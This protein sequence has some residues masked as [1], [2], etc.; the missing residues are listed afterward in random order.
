M[1][2]PSAAS[3]ASEAFKRGD[4]A[5]AAAAYSEALFA[6]EDAEA[7]S[8]ALANRAQCN[9][10]L[11]CFAEGREDAAAAR[12]LTPSNPKAWYRLGSCEARLAN[13]TESEAAFLEAQA[14][15][16]NDR[17]IAQAVGT[18]RRRRLESSGRYSWPEVYERYLAPYAITPESDGAAASASNENSASVKLVLGV[19]PFVGPLRIGHSPGRGRGLF[20]TED[21]SAGQLLLCAHAVAAGENEKLAGLLGQSLRRSAELREAVLGLSHGTESS[22]SCIPSLSLRQLAAPRDLQADKG[23][24]GDAASEEELRTILEFNQFSLPI[25][26]SNTAPIEVTNDLARSGLW[27][28]PAFVNHSCV[29]NVQ[30]IIVCDCLFLRSG[31]DLRA[32]E[33]LFDCYIE[34]LQPLAKRV[35][36]LSNYGI[37][38]C[39]CERCSLERA[40]LDTDE[41][42]G[43]IEMAAKAKEYPT[44]EGP[45]VA[46][47]AEAAALQAEVVVARALERCFQEGRMPRLE[48]LAV[49]ALP[50]SAERMALLREGIEKCADASEQISFEQ[51]DRLHKLLLGSLGNVLRGYAMSLRGL[52]RYVDASVAWTRV[53]DVLEQVLPC[54]ELSA[55]VAAE[56][57]SAKLQ[58]FNLDFRK[59]CRPTFR[60]ALLTGQRSYGGGAAAW[61]VLNKQTFAMSVLDGA[62]ELFA[63]L[64][65]ELGLADDSYDPAALTP[66]LPEAIVRPQVGFE[67]LLKRR[68]REEQRKASSCNPFAPSGTNSRTTAASSASG[69]SASGGGAR[70]GGGS[71]G[72]ASGGDGASA[73]NGAYPAASST[74]PKA[75]PGAVTATSESNAAGAGGAA[76]EAAHFEVLQS[77]PGELLV[78]VS[79]PGLASAAEAA[80]EVADREVRVSSLRPECP[81]SLKISLPLLVDP[82]SSVARWSKR[83]QQLTV[84]LKTR[85]RIC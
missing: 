35:G 20:V 55:I 62:A 32:G 73:P 45:A 72:G 67:D 65:E 16:P 44:E 85:E 80:L 51:Q 50:I 15:R 24:D 70:G 61:C 84:R 30:R 10:R 81:H 83:K 59:A 22:E 27:L 12:A 7:R 29:P 26:Q 47:K 63:S 17:D 71:C 56:M 4:F 66:T 46:A 28:L 75:S 39:Y 42:Q 52:N 34:T 69:D 1:S 78:V 19:E 82:A 60:R 74:A 8:A 5:A 31:R 3:D 41:V 79:L 38:E 40:V 58:A 18:V 33:E 53:H 9:L 23:C 6:A 64:R 11:G 14:L 49:P 25:V 77:Q 57:L 68:G 13:F 54:S 76:A 36:Q 21:V 48:R 2:I 43:V 37:A